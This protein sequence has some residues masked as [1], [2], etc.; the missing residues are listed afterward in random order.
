ME[1]ANG[2]DADQYRLH[3]PLGAD[4]MTVHMAFRSVNISHNVDEHA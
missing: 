1:V 4:C 3:R 2:P